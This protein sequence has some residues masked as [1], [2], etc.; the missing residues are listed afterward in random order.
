M[1]NTKSNLQV[2]KLKARKN[3]KLINSIIGIK[4]LK[5]I[6]KPTTQ[7]KL[8]RKLL[9]Y[10]YLSIQKLSSKSTRQFYY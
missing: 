7:N 1:I 2:K 4:T 3:M 10:W 5:D 8:I 9:E 6:M